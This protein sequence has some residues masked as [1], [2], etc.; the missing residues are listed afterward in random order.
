M[1]I[2]N[3]LLA[4]FNTALLPINLAFCFGGVFLG[5]FIGV[6]PGLGSLAAISMLL[7]ITYYVE[8]TTALVLLAGVY[9]GAEYG[10]AVASILLNIP[11]TPASAVV[12]V[13]GYPLARQG[14]AGVALFTSA[15]SSF[16]GGTMGI[17]AL[18]LFAPSLGELALLFGPGDY[19][20]LMVVGLVAAP[21]VSR[22]SSLKGIAMVIVGLMLGCIGTDIESG[23][24]RFVFGSNSLFDGINLVALAMGLFGISE[25]V[26]SIGLKAEPLKEKVTFLS[27]LPT[28]KE[29]KSILMPALRGSGIGG[30]LGAIPGTGPTIASFMSYAIERSVAKDK[31]RFGKGALE[32]VA[33]PEASNN[34]AVITAFIP[35]LTIGIPGTATMALMLGALIIHGISPGPALINETPEVFWGLIA[36]FWI[37]NIILLFLNIPLIGLWVRLLKI[38]YI[39]M[40]PAIVC[41]ICI[42]VFS[43]NN[44]LF[45]VGMVLAIGALGYAMRLLEFEPAPLLVGFVLGPLMEET[46]RRSMLLSNGDVTNLFVSPISGTFLGLAICLVLFGIYKSFKSC[47]AELNPHLNGN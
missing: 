46:L 14:R 27:M 39:H 11:G 25:L 29:L 5:T 7:P 1:T 19:F 26:I 20:A 34:A 3:D 4:G 41:L 12:C 37:G 8:P 47:S 17:F 40:Y 23:V 32:G 16:I 45:D 38:P 44:S 35:T 42:G 24:Q 28:K 6:L 13:D 10:G 18:M 22:G 33:A 43:I 9:Y 31:T 15:I 2:F 21:A 36:S 30:L